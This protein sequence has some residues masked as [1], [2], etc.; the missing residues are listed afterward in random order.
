LRGDPV[1]K[2]VNHHLTYSELAA[3]SA[4]DL[5]D[6][7]EER[8]LDEYVAAS[9]ELQA[10]VTTLHAVVADLAYSAPSVPLASSVKNRLFLRIAAPE[11]Q[12][13]EQLI[14]TTP[15]VD[16]P[17]MVKLMEQATQ[18]TWKRFP[19]PI[20]GV[21][22]GILYEDLDKREAEVF[23]RAEAGVEMFTHQ[24]ASTEEMIVLEGDL[25]VNGQVYYPGDRVVSQLG[26]V[27]SPGTQTG[28]LVYVRSSLDDDYQ[29]FLPTSQSR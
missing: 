28:C 22:M 1:Y 11:L 8:Q 15:K 27:H 23:I 3:L 25:I 10:D 4:L 14:S 26:S 12:V 2:V 5:L 16:P 24:H 17:L 21:R 20:W 19:I 29:Q 13:Q 6:A 9:P 7:D 18:V